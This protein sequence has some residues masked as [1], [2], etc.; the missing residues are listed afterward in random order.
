MKQIDDQQG[1]QNAK[2]E[3]AKV[4]AS[5]TEN[6]LKTVA[7]TVQAVVAQEQSEVQTRDAQMKIVQG[8]EAS[9]RSF[10]QQGSR[11][12]ATVGTHQK[13]IAELQPALQKAN[14]DL[15][16]IRETLKA[17]GDKPVPADQAR[18]KQLSDQVNKLTAELES[19]SQSLATAQANLEFFQSAYGK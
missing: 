18:E 15:A 7:A 5:N 19:A 10:N 17:A 3:P 6:A 13:R 1:K 2:V 14:A 11:L 4:A 12:T 16:A 9:Q 8:L